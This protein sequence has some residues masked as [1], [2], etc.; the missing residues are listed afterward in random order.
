MQRFLISFASVTL[1]L[2]A[3]AFAAADV[4][5]GKQLYMDNC[6]V[7]HGDQGQGQ[8]KPPKHGAQA[9]KLAGD[10]AY[11]EFA[12]FKRAVMEGVDDEGAQLKAP[13]P[14]FETDGLTKPK[15]AKPT[16]EQLESIQAFLKT[17]GPEE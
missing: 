6:A 7:C 15:G 11:W 5:A 14:V 12:D 9:V 2:S 1:I 16:D 4:G 10:A 3:Q 13:M 8:A 17:L